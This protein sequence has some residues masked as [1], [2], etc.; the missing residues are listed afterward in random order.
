MSPR[1][2]MIFAAGLGTCMGALTRDR[3]KPLIRSPAGR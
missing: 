2:V 1:A 3:P